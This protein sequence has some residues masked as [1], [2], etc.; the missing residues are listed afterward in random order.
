MNLV[1]STLP[2]IV[3]IEPAVFRDGR[4]LFFESY[5]R[6][7]YEKVGIR[8]EFVQDNQSNS[9][10][11]TLRGLHL[12]IRRPQ[13]KLVRVLQGEIFDVAVDVRVG[14]PT[15]GKWMS[16]VLSAENFR[17]IFVPTGFA[18]GFV[19]LSET[20]NVE[21]KCSDFYDPGGEV[22]IRWDDPEIGIDWNVTD[23]LLSPKDVKNASLRD[24]TSSLPLYQP[25][26]V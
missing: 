13:A 10:K 7:K 21:Y 23:P 15:F 19:V 3:I 12:Q 24:L 11:G 5:H 6:E 9:V 25:G 8:P 17:Q 22:G 2:G 4:G 16:V 26:A 1:A 14:S 18:H 20:A